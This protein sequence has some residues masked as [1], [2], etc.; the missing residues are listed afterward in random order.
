MFDGGMTPLIVALAASADDLLPLLV[1]SGADVNA[2]Q[3]M[4]RMTPLTWACFLGSSRETVRTLLELGARVDSKCL[5]MARSVMWAGIGTAHIDLIAAERRRGC[6]GVILARPDAAP[7]ALARVGQPAGAVVL[8][9]AKY[10]AA[11]RAGIERDD[12]LVRCDET[13]I[14]GTHD[15]ADV[16]LTRWAGDRVDVRLL[17]AG[18]ILN[19]GIELLPG[20]PRTRYVI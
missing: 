18:E 10:S 20:H 13:S 19:V 3:G 17:R 5:Q 12:V 4:P 2:Q 8:G 1:A 16:L 15:L 14:G 7:L 11:E 6:L 9:V